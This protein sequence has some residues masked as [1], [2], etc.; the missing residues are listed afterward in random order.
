MKRFVAAI[1]MVSAVKTRGK[2]D[3][4]CTYNVRL[5]RDRETIVAVERNKYYIFLWACVCRLSYPAYK[6]HAPYCD[7]S[8]SSIFFLH[9]LINGMI[10]RKTL[11]NT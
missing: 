11:L 10:I 8:G 7:L 6:A 9:Y 5:R 1:Y 3:R 2:Q 4:Q